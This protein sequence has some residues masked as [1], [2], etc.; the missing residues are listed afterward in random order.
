MVRA[1]PPMAAAAGA[2]PVASGAAA[3]DA[4]P[5]TAWRLD[6]AA[7]DDA[8]EDAECGGGGAAPRLE[9][10]P[11]TISAGMPGASPLVTN[12]AVAAGEG[13]RGEG[14]CRAAACLLLVGRGGADETVGTGTATSAGSVSWLEPRR[15]CL[16]A[17]LIGTTRALLPIETLRLGCSTTWV[18]GSGFG[19]RRALGW[20]GA[21]TGKES[22]DGAAAAGRGGNEGEA[23]C[24]PVVT[25]AAA[26]ASRA[27]VKEAVRGVAVLPDERGRAGTAARVVRCGSAAACMQAFAVNAG[28]AAG[29]VSDVSSRCGGVSAGWGREVA[30]FTSLAVDEPACFAGACDWAGGVCTLTSGGATGGG[31]AS[32]PAGAVTV[33]ERIGG[34]SS[35]GA[36]GVSSANR[37]FSRAA[38]RSS[39]SS[40]P[41]SASM[42]AS[43][44]SCSP[45]VSA[46]ALDA[47]GSSPARAADRSRRGPSSE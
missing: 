3:R 21:C 28:G 47:G 26:E 29:D 2:A 7:A 9:G 41:L 27:D 18:A 1:R 42:S 20:G 17:S 38:M 44:F 37:R 35:G 5:T 22:P 40:L 19:E 43:P 32:G 30:S 15:G 25:R 34:A 39:L 45:L 13:G 14:A 4:P 8:V 12:S 46:A 23:P 33:W 16:A 6:S 24:A 31:S 11:P 10:R 36:D